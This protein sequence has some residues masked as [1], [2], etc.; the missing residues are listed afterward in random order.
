MAGFVDGPFDDSL[1]NLV[2]N[3]V[4]WM[5]VVYPVSLVIRRLRSKF[6]LADPSFGPARRVRPK[7]R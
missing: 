3:G 6:L 7:E 5:A 2:I 4:C 1:A